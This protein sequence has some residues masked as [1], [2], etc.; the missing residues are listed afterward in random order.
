MLGLSLNSIVAGPRRSVQRFK[1]A[2]QIRR[3]QHLLN[4]MKAE[5]RAGVKPFSIYT[6]GYYHTGTRWINELII[7]NTPKGLVYSPKNQHRYIDDAYRIAEFQKHGRL[8]HDIL[9]QQRCVI[10]YMVRDFE[11][12]IQ[13]FLNN[14]YEVRL[15]GDI[16][17]STYGWPSLNVYDLYAQVIKTNIA[18]LRDSGRNYVIANMGYCQATQG[19]NLLELLERNGV[20]FTHPLMPI[21]RHTKDTEARKLKR[22]AFDISEYK[23]HAD[24]ELEDLLDSTAEALEYRFS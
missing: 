7:A 2:A 5:N 1:K 17:S 16:A 3:E 22:R 13:S 23:H 20:A 21:V 8:D 18:L 9:G 24:P 19:M 14:P 12:W 11:T 15:T 4:K 6:A 10:I